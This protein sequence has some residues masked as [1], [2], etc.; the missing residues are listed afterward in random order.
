MS[1]SM[2]LD[3][4]LNGAGQ[5]A[6][7]RKC[8]VTERCLRSDLLE[9]RMWLVTGICPLFSIDRP[10]ARRGEFDQMAVRVSKVEAP[11]PGFPGAF[12]FHRDSS[13]L[14]PCLPLV[15]FGRWNSERDVQFSVS[16]V[17]RLDRP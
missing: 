7:W 12:L 14:E 6:A 2:P 11:A 17:R 5:K 13:C 15:Q 1:C 3:G 9:P 4:T 10:C 16:V 8:G